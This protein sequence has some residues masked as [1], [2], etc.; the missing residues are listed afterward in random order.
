MDKKLIYISVLFVSLFLISSCEEFPIPPQESMPCEPGDPYYPDC[1]EQ[2]PE[3]PLGDDGDRGGG[4]DRTTNCEDFFYG[5]CN[6]PDNDDIYEVYCSITPNLDCNPGPCYAEATNDLCGYPDDGY[7]GECFCIGDGVCDSLYGENTENSND[8][9]CTPGEVQ[10]CPTGLFGICSE[11]ERTCQEGGT[12]GE[13]VPNALPG[14]YEEDCDDPGLL[15]EDCDAS[16][17]EGDF[18]SCYYG[19]CDVNDECQD[20]YCPTNDCVAECVDD[21]DCVAES[22]LECIFI[23]EEIGLCGEVPGPGI[24][25]CGVVGEECSTGGQTCSELANDNQIG[26]CCSEGQA[27]DGDGVWT[28]G[29]SDC[30]DTC[31]VYEEWGGCSSPE[32]CVLTNTHLYAGIAYEGDIVNLQASGTSSCAGVEV[33]FT[34]FEKDTDDTDSVILNPESVV[35][36]EG[37]YSVLTTW[38]SEWQD[39]SD[40]P[41]VPEGGSPSFPEF[42]FTATLASNPDESIT[43]DAL[44]TVFDATVLEEPI[45][46]DI[47]LNP[48]IAPIAQEEDSL[49]RY[50]EVM[51]SGQMISYESG[52][53][54]NCGANSN[55]YYTGD[56]QSC[57]EIGGDSPPIYDE[58]SGWCLV[59]EDPFCPYT[60]WVKCTGHLDEPLRVPAG[61]RSFWEII[62]QWFQSTF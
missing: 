20:E 16:S 41:G 47:L 26:V 45:G 17:N 42:G 23:N 24:D 28:P 38:V 50:C 36:A 12:W 10:D 59:D 34:M 13:C 4:G 39:D 51:T 44:V 58:E 61:Q 5:N 52:E 56:E 1:P 60:V 22:H 19:G 31:C 15:D 37:S 9:E 43:D 46:E 48:G 35:F 32:D 54:Q 53:I 6:Q 25:E 62:L 40:D 21:A 8:C 14:E 55:W 29:S 2:P 30:P 33:V 27:C 57:I 18:D 3:I 7:V 11:G 49:D